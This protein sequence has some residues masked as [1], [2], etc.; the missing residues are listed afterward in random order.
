MW[1][2]GFQDV[3]DILNQSVTIVAVTMVAWHSVG[4]LYGHAGTHVLLVIVHVHN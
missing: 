3:L 4:V 1:P 2:F